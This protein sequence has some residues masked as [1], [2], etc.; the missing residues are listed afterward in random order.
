MII[1]ISCILHVLKR[2]VYKLYHTSVQ[3][4]Y[5]GDLSQVRTG[6]AGFSVMSMKPVPFLAKGLGMVFSTQEREVYLY[7][8]RIH[9]F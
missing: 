9:H 7:T 6:E 5:D 4:F 3:L 8:R 2:H 1:V